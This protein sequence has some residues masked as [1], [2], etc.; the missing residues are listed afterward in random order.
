MKTMCWQTYSKFKK[1]LDYFL[2]RKNLTH[3]LRLKNLIFLLV[4]YFASKDLKKKSASSKSLKDLVELAISYSLYLINP[5]HPLTTIASLQVKSELYK[6][7]KVI[8]SRKPKIIVEI[9]TANGGTL[10]LLSKLSSPESIIISIDLPYH[11]N[12]LGIDYKPKFFFKSF[13]SNKQKMFL[14]R[15]NSHNQLVLEKLKQILKGKEIDVLFLDGDHTYKGV[16][17]D[18]EM[19]GNLVRK[20]GIIAFHDI[21]EVKVVD[22]VQVNQFWNEI[23][24]DYNYLEFVEDWSQDTCGIGIIFKNK[25]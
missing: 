1:K 22:D 25:I 7:S 5:F 15:G 3:L 17:M 9:G 24:E 2:I 14:I 13:V 6:F 21:V 19:Y 11:P 23:K 16:K 12:L 20:N 8:F 10:F 18:F 4:Y